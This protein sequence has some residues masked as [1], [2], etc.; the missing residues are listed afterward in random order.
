LRE[1]RRLQL[2]LL[3]RRLRIMRRRLLLL[4]L[5]HLGIKLRRLFLGIIENL[6]VCV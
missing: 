4:S 3:L 1:L 5:L 6:C 2:L